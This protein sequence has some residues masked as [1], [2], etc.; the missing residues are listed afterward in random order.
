MSKLLCP[1]NGCRENLTHTYPH[2]CP[3]CWYRLP[4]D[5]REAVEFEK[6]HGKNADELHHVLNAAVQWLHNENHRLGA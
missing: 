6:R 3:T 5:Y 1:V 2:I 4:V